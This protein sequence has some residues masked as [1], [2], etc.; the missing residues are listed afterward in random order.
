MCGFQSGHGLNFLYVVLLQPQCP[1]SVT[2]HKTVELEKCSTQT[3]V[4]IQN[5][6]RS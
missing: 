1:R 6:S 2:A 5:L 4:R 3:N